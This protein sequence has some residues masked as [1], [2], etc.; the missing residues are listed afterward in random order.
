MSNTNFDNLRTANITRAIEWCGPDNK[1]SLEFNTIELCGE[2]GELANAIK[3]YLR[4]KM[5]IPGGVNNLDNIREEIADV[6]ICADLLAESLG[7]NLGD[8]VRD[9]FNRTSEKHNFN[10]KLP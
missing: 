8:A 1:C 4:F 9:K 7:I 3:K 5:G 6:V 2:T 10:T